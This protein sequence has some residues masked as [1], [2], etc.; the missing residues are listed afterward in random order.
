MNSSRDTPS[1]RGWTRR[2]RQGLPLLACLA[3]PLALPASESLQSLEG[4]DV[5]IIAEE[6]RT[7]YEYRQNGQ[8]RIV[9]IEPKWG[10]PYYLVP[11]DPTTGYGD[12]ERADALLPSWKLFEF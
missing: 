8:L 12:L 4:P 3:S 5:V 7:I 9:K 6:E 1:Y 11:R 10:K 2:L